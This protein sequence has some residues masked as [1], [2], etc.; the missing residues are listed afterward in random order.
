MTELLLIMNKLNLNS[1][2]YIF[3]NWYKQKY[4]FLKILIYNFR[5][6]FRNKKAT[7]LLKLNNKTIL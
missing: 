1:L 7:S 2:H 3:K 6:K 4:N 5:N